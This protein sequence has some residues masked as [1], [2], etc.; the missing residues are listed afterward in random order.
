MRKLELFLN[1]IISFSSNP[2]Y[3][4]FMG[5]F[6]IA[7]ISLLFIL[8]LII[9]KILNPSIAAGWV[10]TISSIYFI[11]GAIISSIGVLGLY[12]GRI[13]NEVKRRPKYLIKQKI[14]GGKYE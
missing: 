14:K 4:I 7:A 12:V 6:I 5:G 1:S 11:G 10:S 13:F 8:G 9:Y 2:L 3:Y